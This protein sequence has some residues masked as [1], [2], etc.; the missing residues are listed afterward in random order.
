MLFQK[1]TTLDQEI[2]TIDLEPEAI[3][4]IEDISGYYLTDEDDKLT[5]HHIYKSFGYVADPHGAIG[6]AAI[7]DFQIDH[8]DYV[9]VYLE[10]AHPAKFLNVMEEVFEEPITI[11][12]RLASLAQ[13]EKEADLIQPKFEDLKLWLLQRISQ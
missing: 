10:T 8:P 6:Y 12:E 2:F 13:K 4:Y 11:P 3:K 1:Y 5:M 7:R 9:G